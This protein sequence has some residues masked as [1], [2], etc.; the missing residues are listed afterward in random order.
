MPASERIKRRLERRREASAQEDRANRLLFIG[1]IAA[2]VVAIGYLL[3]KNYLDSGPVD[4]NRASAAKLESLP[5][6]GPDTAAAIIKARPFTTV[7]DLD[8]VKGIGPATLEK[9]R[10]RVTVGD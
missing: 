10:P 8:K 9:L 1:I 4:L 2:F 5:G 7:D 3:V 6:V